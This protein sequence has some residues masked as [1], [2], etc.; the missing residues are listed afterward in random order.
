[1]HID[2]SRIEE[3]WKNAWEANGVY[4]VS[5]ESDKPKY[6]VLDMFP[7]PSGAGL[8]VG[9]PLG[10]IAS[11][12]IS[13]F[14]RMDGY[15]VLHPMGYDA[16]GLPAEQYAIQTGIHPSISTE[17]NITKFRGQLFNLGLSYDWTREIKT[18]NPSYYKWT[19]WIFLQLYGHFYDSVQKTARP[20]EE[21]AVE[22]ERNGNVE[23]LEF[24]AT[25]DESAFSADDW[26]AMTPKEKDD[27]LMRYRLA[28]RDVSYVNWCEA[29]GTVLANDEVKDGVSERGGHPVERKAMKQWSLRITAYADRLLNDLQDLDWSESMKT[30]QTNWIGRS[31]GAE[32]FFEVADADEAIKIFTTRPDTIFGATFMVIAPEHPLVDMITT[33]DQK[34]AIDKYKQYVSTRTERE[35]M[36]DVKE[37][38]GEFTGAYAINPFSEER[39]PIWIADYVL[40]DYGTGAIMAV[41]GDDTRDA[42]FA[43]TFGIPVIEV[44]DRSAHPGAEMQDKV[45][46]M[47]NSGFLT[48]MSVLDAIA[49]I[50]SQIEERGIGKRRVQYKMRDAIYSRQRY[51][52]EP[53]PVIFDENGVSYADD[54]SSLPLELPMLDNFEPGSGT[55]PLARAEDWV[56]LPGGKRRET[57]TMPG[58]AGSSWYFLRYMDPGND[59]QFASP[60]ALNYWRDVDLYIGGTEHAVGHLMYARFWHKFLFDKGLLPSNEPFR[61]LINQG[62]I[63]G[64]IE[65]LYMQKDK[66]DGHH[67][68]LSARLAANYT[69]VEFVRIA[70]PIGYVTDYG[71]KD[72]Y[73]NISGVEQL[74][75]WRPE[76]GDAIF[77]CDNGTYHKG[78]F[79]PVNGAADLQLYHG[80]RSRKNG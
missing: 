50:N 14:K 29:L 61:K 26:A 34:E 18:C 21:L 78:V 41:P 11:D 42:N 65:Y 20:I 6:Y 19:Q 54:E 79:T 66:V 12:I 15:N 10:Y 64:V 30:I 45:G 67:R 47:I 63:Q 38:T 22:F 39:I 49:A 36:T 3:K 37:V 5:N 57:D 35:R 68:F 28:Y 27:I 76:Y 1:M 9:H 40:Y 73:L 43:N 25:S 17:D 52:G 72:S 60:Q 2:F 23:A 55:A 53:I 58:Y 32:L 59:T 16:F 46:T 13:R 74:I 62:M 48:G 77:E 7:Y 4:H 33:D 69:D 70:V 80:V 31:E 51:W 75:A 24:A 8:H 56:N 71:S 44:V